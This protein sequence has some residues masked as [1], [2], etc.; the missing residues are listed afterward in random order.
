MDCAR[1]LQ[2]LGLTRS[3]SPR[4]SLNWD[5]RQMTGEF[6]VSTNAVAEMDVF[7]YPSWVFPVTNEY[8]HPLEGLAFLTQGKEGELP[9]GP[10]KELTDLYVRLTREKDLEK[11]H[12]LIREAV[13]IHIKEGPI[14]LG[15]RRTEAQSDSRLQPFSQRA[16]Q[17]DHWSLGDRT[18]R[19][20]LS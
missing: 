17:R 20:Q 10:L 2:K 11:R 14:H 1:G 5:L 13:R 7:T 8:W 16:P 19:D 3:S 18:P 12:A 4:N 15:H 6:T 9:S